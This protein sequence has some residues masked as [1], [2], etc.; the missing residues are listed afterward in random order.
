MD[1][2]TL[3]GTFFVQLLT[4]LVLGMLIGAERT[5]AG[6]TAGLRTYGL[7]AMGSCLFIVV[8]LG[9]KDSLGVSGAD[10]MRVV[11]GIITGIGFLGAGVIILRDQTLVGLTT[12]A[13]L[14]VASGIGVA[15]GFKLYEIAFYT[16]FLTLLTFTVFWFI[17]RGVSHMGPQNNV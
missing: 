4:A 12:A 16:T 13:G 6:K 3:G 15:I 9:L 14:W 1:I 11:A 7:V 8:S 10:V 5:L 2:T 17:E